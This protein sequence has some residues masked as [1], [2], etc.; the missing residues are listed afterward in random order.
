MRKGFDGGIGF[1]GAGQL[2]SQSTQEQADVFACSTMINIILWIKIQYLKIY[3][4]F[5]LTPNSFW[6]QQYVFILIF[7]GIFIVD[8]EWNVGITGISHRTEPY[9]GCTITR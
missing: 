9:I 2:C 3:I 4:Q 6:I 1:G 8:L 5:F 7:G